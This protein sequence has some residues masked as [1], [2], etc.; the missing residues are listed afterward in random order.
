MID[1]KDALDI[2]SDHV[3]VVRG[4]CLDDPKT[5]KGCGQERIF[6][7]RAN[8]NLIDDETHMNVIEA[9]RSIL[10]HCQHY[11]FG[12]TEAEYQAWKLTQNGR[13]M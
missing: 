3:R 5:G 9:L 6:L 7:I 10:D 1:V 8:A 2:P 11:H 13:P 4:L 12:N